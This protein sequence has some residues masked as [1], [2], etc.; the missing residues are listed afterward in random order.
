MPMVKPVSK[1]I[2]ACINKPT[3]DM[4]KVRAVQMGVSKEHLVGYILKDWCSQASAEGDVF[5]Q[6]QAELT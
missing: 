2:R 4:I 5:R 3:E 1:T 6:A